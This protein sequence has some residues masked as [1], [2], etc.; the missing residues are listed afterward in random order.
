MSG[1]AKFKG[2][3]GLQDH[4]K[5]TRALSG[6]YYLH[7][8]DR[9]RGRRRLAGRETI[10][11]TFPKTPSSALYGLADYWPLPA[12]LRPRLH[13]PDTRR[14]GR[15]LA[16]VLGSS[17]GVEGRKRSER[18]PDARCNTDPRGLLLG[19][20]IRSLGESSEEDPS[21]PPF[22]PAISAPVSAPKWLP[23][24]N[25]CDSI[26]AELCSARARHSPGHGAC[27]PPPNPDLI[28][29]AAGPHPCAAASA[30]FL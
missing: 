9:G 12:A 16:G 22:L 20:P 2:A 30:K 21:L 13:P 26:P 24:T 10:K 19:C 25:R 28:A 7:P 27:R 1:D 18:G 15:G 8:K 4:L 23:P 11:G 17:K 3:E 14:S 5:R 29:P 6:R